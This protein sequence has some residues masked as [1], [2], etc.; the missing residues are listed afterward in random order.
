MKTQLAASILA[1]CLCACA[2]SGRKIELAYEGGCAHDH[3]LPELKLDAADRKLLARRSDSPASAADCY[4][5]LPPSYFSNV[6]NTPERRAT[7]V[8]RDS[9]TSHY[10]HA[11]HWFEC[12][13][14]GFEVTIRVFDAA[15]GPLVA[16]LSSTYPQETL[17]NNQ[18]APVGDLQGIAVNRPRFW[19]FRDGKWTE[20]DGKI[21]PAID[22]EFVL[23]RYRNHYKA[24]LKNADQQKS[25]WLEYE[26]PATG[27]RV[28]LTGRENFM[29]PGETYTWKS[30]RFNG[31]RFVPEN[32]NPGDR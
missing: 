8:D 25:I 30:F 16:I 22:K 2:N 17:L 19:R 5:L 12:D 26:L 24:H 15:D 14:G 9:L 1:V 4:F 10:L 27:G 28:P 11:K 31:K 32:S 20:V 21:L 23:D 18:G 3:R 6:E 13:G 7:L 29:D